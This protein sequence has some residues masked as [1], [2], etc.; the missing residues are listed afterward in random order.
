MGGRATWVRSACLG[1]C[2]R[3][4]AAL[5]SAAG[6]KLR[7]RVLAPATPEGIRSLVD[8][9]LAGRLPWQPDT[10]MTDLSV[11]QAGARDLRLLRRIGKTSPASLRDYRA[12]GGYAAL[13]RA[14]DL[15]PDGVIRGLSAPRLVGRGGAAFPTARKWEALHKQ[16]H[17]G[18]QHYVVCNADESE[19][20]TFKD[21]ILMEGDPFA[22]LE[23]MTIAAV[24]TGAE[25]GYI[26]L[27]GEYF[28]AAQRIQQAI[29]SATE[30]GF[31]GD[32]ILGS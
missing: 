10:L 15:G 4:P 30:N 27:R 11:P 31:L 29:D 18:R 23:G 26:Y 25:Q 19:P 21:R 9:A 24:A 3:A 7:E 2:E 20:G 12:Q 5:I 17:L 1:L 8:D 13:Q 14:L 22:V 28:L 6:E 32:N 16:R